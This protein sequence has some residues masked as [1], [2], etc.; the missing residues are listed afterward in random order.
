M[1]PHVLLDARGYAYRLE[2]FPLTG[3]VVLVDEKAPIAVSK[4][5]RGP[6]T[7]TVLAKAHSNQAIPKW[8]SP[9]SD[10]YT[11]SVAGA[12][13]YFRMFNEDRASGRF[14]EGETEPRVEIATLSI[15]SRQRHFTT[16]KSRE[17][18]SGLY[19]RP[20]PGIEWRLMTTD[21]GA[22]W[23]ETAEGGNSAMMRGLEKRGKGP[24]ASELIGALSGIE[25]WRGQP[26]GLDWAISRL[27]AWRLERHPQSEPWRSTTAVNYAV[28]RVRPWQSLTEVGPPFTLSNDHLLQFRYNAQRRELVAFQYVVDANPL[29]EIYN[30]TAHVVAVLSLQQVNRLSKTPFDG[31]SGLEGVEQVLNL[32]TRLQIG[33]PL[34]GPELGTGLV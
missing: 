9:F 10:A 16:Y 21:D 26:D 13:Y 8:V 22:I 4:G 28:D 14:Y 29:A 18:A 2:Y 1:S 32:A 31:R 27:A 12:L 30:A 33:M 11:C 20:F 3:E 19:A 15:Y 5:S 34:D 23:A 6:W 17:M 25:T 24:S 7:A